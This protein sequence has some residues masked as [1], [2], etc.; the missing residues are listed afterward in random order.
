[1]L[2]ASPQGA[3][4]VGL[5]TIQLCRTLFKNITVITTSGQYSCPECEDR[6]TRLVCHAGSEEKVKV[7]KEFGANLSINYKEQNFA[8]EVLAFTGSK[9][10]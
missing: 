2:C 5:A 10:M 6:N 4:G 3:S 8:D 7:C 1:M 9:G